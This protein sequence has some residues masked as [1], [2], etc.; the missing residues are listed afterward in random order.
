MKP[1]QWRWIDR[2]RMYGNA[3]K[4]SKTTKAQFWYSIKNF[5]LYTS[6]SR[7]IVKTWKFSLN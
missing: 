3:I 4:V 5:T 1:L 7:D 6:I 2:H